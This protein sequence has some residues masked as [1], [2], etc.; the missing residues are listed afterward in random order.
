MVR[1]VV[2]W[3]FKSEAEGQNK[4]ENIQYVKSELEKLPSV[5]D[6]ILTLDVGLNIKDNSSRYEMVLI[7]TH[8]SK[9]MLDHYRGHPDHSKIAGYIG[10]VTEERFLVDFEY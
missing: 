10:K 5:I 4:E 8:Q 3:R 1:H 9:E 2:M 7:S 6:S